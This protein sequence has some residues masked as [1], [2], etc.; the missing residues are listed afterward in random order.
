MIGDITPLDEAKPKLPRSVKVKLALEKISE[1]TVDELH[2]ILTEHKGEARLLFNLERSGDFM[3]VMD[4]EGY[5]VM[6]DH[7]FIARVEEL[8]GKDTVKAVD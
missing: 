7:A 5:N 6:P 8:C 2:R 3:V 4:A 1:G